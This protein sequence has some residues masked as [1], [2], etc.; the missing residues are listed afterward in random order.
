MAMGAAA[1][2]AAGVSGAA[3]PFRFAQL[4]L[5]NPHA[6]GWRDCLE[7]TPG[8]ELV[9]FCE[10]DPAVLPAARLTDAQR[11]LPVYGDLDALVRAAR[12]DAVLIT[13]PNDETAVAMQRAAE[14]GLHVFAEK[15]CARTAAELQPAAAAI[16]RAG[17]QFGTGYLRRYSAIGQAIKEMVDTGL[18]GRLVSIEARWIAT[19]VSRRGPSHY[20]FQRDRSGGGM[21]HWLG[22]HWLDFMRWTTSSEVTSVAAILETRSDEP[23]DVED[24]AAVALGYDNGMVGSLH[25]AYVTDESADQLYFGLRGT[26]GWVRWERSGPEVEL[27]SAHPAWATAPTRTLRV[28]GAQNAGYG[29][30]QGQAA[31]R[32]FVAAARGEA[33]PVFSVDDA[34]RI[35]EVLDAAQ[36]SGASGERVRL[37]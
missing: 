33:K 31:L 4:G 32:N 22:C 23:I 26:L 9:A 29:D 24:V 25:V 35:L 10:T 7:R 30:G 34:L 28:S 6:S 5:N 14:A 15:P 21:L 2:S 37:G 8:M 13:L 18:L 11:A 27:H 19:S 17:V 1:A 16:R 36:R 3:R 20:V 12:P